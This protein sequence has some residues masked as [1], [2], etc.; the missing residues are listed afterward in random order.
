MPDPTHGEQPFDPAWWLP[1]PHFQTL[2]GRLA[3]PR[4]LVPLR[5]EIL[6]TPDDDDLV[7]DHVDG[8]PLRRVLILH[9]LEGSS[10][11]VYVQGMLERLR[12]A[13]V[14]ATVVNFRACARSPHRL[15][16]WIPN[17]GKRL[18]HSGETTDLAWYLASLRECA[19]AA[20]IAAIGV[21]LGGNVLL[22]YL[23]ERGAEAGIRRAAT[24][25]VPYDL[26]AG[27]DHLETIMG[28][29]Y[30][31]SFVRSLTKKA[32]R[33]L[34]R[35]TIAG[36]DIPRGRRA[37]TFR[38]FD[39]ALTAPIHGFRDADHYYEVA[40][41]IH[42][43]HRVTV[44]TLCISAVD[45]PFIPASVLENV[46]RLKSPAV[47]LV[48]ARGGGHVGFVSGSPLSPDYWAERQAV[49]F[50]LESAA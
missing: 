47:E 46:A 6:T 50:V 31:R 16:E 18:Y 20:D 32:E 11:S 37:W 14:T 49:R 42:Y 19:P 13:G 12:G 30:V 48:T 45:D 35:H 9:G 17:R 43:V 44:P 7:L 22:K 24:I 1:G 15:S 40:S 4:Q 36:A 34:A 27:A 38:E 33:I 25:S 23:G 28:K 26:G 2:W 10:N 21:S 41:S 8:D 3:R 39:D 5:R 29:I